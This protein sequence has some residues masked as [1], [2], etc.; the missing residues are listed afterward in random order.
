LQEV[1]IGWKK[2]HNKELHNLYPL[3]DTKV[4]K[5]G[6][7][8]REGNGGDGESIRNYGW[9]TQR[10]ETTTM[11]SYP[12]N[13]LMEEYIKVDIWVCTGVTFTAQ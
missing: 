12:L 6:K 1:T 13:P 8:R 9:K 7:M 11:K 4:M 3:T 10:E 2:A 5:F